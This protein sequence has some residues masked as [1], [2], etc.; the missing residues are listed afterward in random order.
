MKIVDWKV[1][2]YPFKLSLFHMYNNAAEGTV[3]L[4]REFQGEDVRVFG[5]EQLELNKALVG[6]ERWVQEQFELSRML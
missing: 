5:I 3:W 2:V 4:V 6:T 1:T